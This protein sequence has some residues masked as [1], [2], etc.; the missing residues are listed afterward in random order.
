M[1]INKGDTRVEFFQQCRARHVLA[2]IRK[3]APFAR[4]AFARSWLS[5]LAKTWGS[6]SVEQ[7]KADMRVIVN[8]ENKTR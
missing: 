8:T 1:A 3:K 7:L 2:E 5:S 4:K 6:D